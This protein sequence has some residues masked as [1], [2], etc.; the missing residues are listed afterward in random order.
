VRCSQR[1]SVTYAGGGSLDIQT[2]PDGHLYVVSNSLGSM[3]EIF[4]PH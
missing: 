3:F 2:G 1:L 4:K